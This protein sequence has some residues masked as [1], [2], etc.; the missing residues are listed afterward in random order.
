[1]RLWFTL[2][3][4]ELYTSL[5]SSSKGLKTAEAN[6]RLRAHGYN[7]LALTRE[8]LWKKIIEPFRSIFA[9]VLLAAAAISFISHENIDAAVILVI[10][11][12]NAAIYYSQQHATNRV[13]D[14]LKRHSEQSATVLR[15]G[16][17]VKLSSRFLVPGDVI[18]LSEGA[19]VPADARILEEENLYVNEASLTGESLPIKKR[20]STLSQN[21][22]IFERDNMAY[23][24]TYV[25]SGTGLAM[26]VSTAMNTE[27]GAIAELAAKKEPKSPM[28]AKID[29]IVGRLIKILIVIVAV[30][31]TLSLV[32]GTPLDEASR[33]AMSLAVA[34]VPEDLPIALTVIM[35]LGMRRLAKKHALVRSPKAIEDL[36]LVTVVATDKTGTLTKNDLYVARYWSLDSDEELK[37]TAQ[38]A[39][40]QTSNT[41]EP[42]DQA[43]AKFV[44][45]VKSKGKLLKNLP[46]NQLQRL[47]GAVWS[48]SGRKVLYIK[49]APE[50]VLGMSRMSAKR[51]AEAEGQL[52]QLVSSGFR[53]I[54]FA[55]TPLDSIPKDLARMKKT[56]YRFSGFVA[57]AD[58]LR[59]DT[60]AAI[61]A[62]H[63]AG[64]SVRMIT[65]DHYETALQ[66]SRALGIGE[67][68]DQIISGK[69]LSPR[70][71][72]LERSVKTKTVFARILPEQKFS[73][74]QALK[75]TDI[76]AMTGDGVNDVPALSNAHVGIAMGSG[77]DIAKDAGDIVLLNNKFSS[78][79]SAISEGRVIYDNVRR[80]LFYLLS[81]TLGE[82]LTMIG[83][84]LLGLPLPVTALQ[85]LWINLVTDSALVIPL[86]LEPP[87]KD[88]MSRPP[89]H[90]K[91]P[92][93]DRLILTRIAIVGAAMAIPTLVVFWY[94]IHLGYPT[95][96]AQ[97]AAFS[98]L[99]VAQWVNAFNA[100][101]ERTS[102]LRRLGTPNY[103]LLAGLS[104]AAV[105]QSLV[106]FGPLG[107]IF[108][109][110]A[111]STRHLLIGGVTVGLS[112]W[113]A[114][115]IHKFI[116]RRRI[117]RLK[118][119]SRRH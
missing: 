87:E 22:K 70:A 108:N 53:A 58:E 71:F 78:I 84:L 30:V 107:G 113:L 103:K 115:E 112:V 65:G 24:G 57:F 95:D 14:S 15:D 114:V 8:P 49:G 59:P 43:L 51:R 17:K 52:H 42:F 6:R 90:P 2:T 99:V 21:K 72:E 25:V 92:I 26:V 79:I 66:V 74:L 18:Y 67:R 31:F 106:I 80:I 62:A 38:K 111:V 7:V 44:S 55:Y 50:H 102:A 109:I 100:R 29:N 5:N 32:R 34:A 4:Q 118:R 10:I 13:L 76:T 94:I 41:I 20:Q 77:N 117:I 3:L 40:G 85:I 9:I 48:E 33:F 104:I 63:K 75:K 86:G 101:S 64:I 11:G 81:T 69:E 93:L 91:A 68:R 56:G 96:Y 36:G 116:V 105:L 27:F 1:M 28:Q 119:T 98:M 47:S 39:L 61:E 54:G 19:R 88:H 97:T 37:K 82:V 12:V 60:K 16:K 73:I 83:A 46:F 110:Q 35:V 89:R 23:A 45:G